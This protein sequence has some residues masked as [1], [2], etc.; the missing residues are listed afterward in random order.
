MNDM[1]VNPK[2]MNEFDE[3]YESENQIQKS[4]QIDKDSFTID[5]GSV[6]FKD[7]AVTDPIKNGR[8]ETYLGLTKSISEIGIMSPIHVMIN[9]GYALWV[10]S[11]EEGEYEGYKYIVLDGFRRIYGG[12]KAGLD[13]CNA[14]IWDFKDK[15]QGSELATTLSL[16]LNKT[17]KRSWSEIWYLMEILEMSS[18]L[19]PGTMEYLLQLE[20]GDAMKL[21]EIMQRADDFP[22]PKNDLLEN[23]K[24]LQQAFN[25]LQKEMKEQDQL[26]MED[27]RGSI[28]EVEQSEGVIN[29]DDTDGLSDS[30]VKEILEMEGSFDDDLSEEDFGELTDSDYERQK[31]GER[32]P[33]SK[34]LKAET[35]SRDNYECQCCGSGKGLPMILRLAMLQSHHKISVANSGPD[36]ADN[37]VTVCQACHSMIHCVLR[38]GLKL[39]MSKKQYDEMPE[40]SKNRC[41]N[42][43]KLAKLDWEAG[44]RLGKTPESMKKDNTNYSRFKMP[45]TDLAENRK[46]LENE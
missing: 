15:E 1:Y 14:V 35:M 10:E 24:T 2:L 3:T 20:Y 32:H 16:V 36:M 4:L 11:G 26:Y 44:L 22:D 8:K 31:V 19:T 23:K 9:E 17:Q 38:A 33:I 5:I 7:C 40:D 34:E 18:N 6:S 42:I 45:G 21:K 27:A 37:I 13:R 41:L 39:G 28:S 46:A 30:E 43:M 12:L 29:E 25:A